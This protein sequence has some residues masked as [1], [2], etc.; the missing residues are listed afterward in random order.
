MEQT[1]HRR[2]EATITALAIITRTQA[3]LAHNHTRRITSK[4]NYGEAISVK[5]ISLYRFSHSNSNNDNW[6]GFDTFE[7]SSQSYQANSAESPH[8]ATSPSNSIKKSHKT[9]KAE[10]SD[11]TS[12]D[13]KSSKAKPANKTKSIEDDAWN[14]LNN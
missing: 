14:L 1:C 10:K 8:A 13:V 9:E 5:L 2:K 12:L 11:F 6:N 3:F 4:F 7:T